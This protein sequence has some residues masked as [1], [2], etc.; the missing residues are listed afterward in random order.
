MSRFTPQT[1]PAVAST[2]GVQKQ[3]HVEQENHGAESSVIKRL[4]AVG[5]N[6][7]SDEEPESSS[8]VK[9]VP[10]TVHINNVL[11]HHDLRKKLK[12]AMDNDPIKGAEGN[13]RSNA[14]RSKNIMFKL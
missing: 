13:E 11:A 7:S 9:T 10:S 3:I 2:S 12:N 8:R 1:K 5:I 6:T 14:T 4:R